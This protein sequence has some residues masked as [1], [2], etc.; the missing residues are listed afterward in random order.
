MKNRY[1]LS[2]EQWDLISDLFPPERGKGRPY[3]PHRGMVNAMMW[4]LNTGAP[5]R[6]LPERYPPWKTVFNRFNRWRKEGLFNKIIERLQLRMNEDGYIDVEL[7]F[8][9]GSNVRA[10]AAAAG[11]GKKGVQ[12]NQATTR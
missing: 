7:W 11:G 10:H 2:D 12:T 5:W 6:D 4:I 3:R 9:D 1:E 8:I